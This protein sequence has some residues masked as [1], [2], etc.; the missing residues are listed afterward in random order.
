MSEPIDAKR[1]IPWAPVV[2]VLAF[3]IG[4][5]LLGGAIFILFGIGWALV[6]TATPFFVLTAVIF[7]GLLRG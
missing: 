6:A 3:L 5:M 2:G 1:S 7:R 4:M